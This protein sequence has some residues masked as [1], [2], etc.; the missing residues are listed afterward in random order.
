MLRFIV[1]ATALIVS[2]TVS[3]QTL[4][5]IK[6]TGQL[7]I[8]FRTDAAPLS[9]VNA[10]GLPAGY[11]PLI[12]DRIAQKIANELKMKDLNATFVAVGAKD[13]FDKVA[14]GDIDLHCG[15]ATITMAR[16]EIVDFSI[17]TYVD[18]T[19]LLLP[20]DAGENLSD[21]TGKKVGMRNGT[22]TQQAVENSFK[23]AG[24][25]SE[26]IRFNDHQAG[27]QAMIDG[28]IDAYFA[29]Q[30]IL[31]V[32]FVAGGMSDR[33][34]MTDQILT[35]EKHGLAIARGDTEFRHL[36]DSV[37]SGLYRDGSMRAFFDKALPGVQ[38]G[39]ALEALYIV[40]PTLP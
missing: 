20:K 21:L 38:P 33:F 36:I 18:G 2:G 3:A 7:N 26:L 14:S 22:T 10:Q 30:S 19:S 13:R 35:I 5:R 31:L 37:I 4:D 12:C 39:P 27:F 6:E 28:E 8:G 24:I 29:D 9:Y 25:D 23:S 40:G 34:K 17:P 15:A 16:R 11:S 32:N 1:A